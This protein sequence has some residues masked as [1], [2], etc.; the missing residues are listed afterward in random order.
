MR[1]ATAW[2]AF[3]GF[4]IFLLS[5]APLGYSLATQAEGFAKELSKDNGKDTAN[6]A[7]L[8]LNSWGERH[9]ARA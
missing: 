9:I 2:I 1:S 7:N 4:P 6:E 3:V 8:R 5:A